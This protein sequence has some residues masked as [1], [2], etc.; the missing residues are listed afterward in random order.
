MDTF[1]NGLTLKLTCYIP[2]IAQERCFMLEQ[3][4][5]FEEKTSIQLEKAI[6]DWIEEEKGAGRIR[7]IISTSIC[8]DQCTYTAIVTYSY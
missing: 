5:S 4:K 6:N 1:V 3:V 7:K 2:N 8:T